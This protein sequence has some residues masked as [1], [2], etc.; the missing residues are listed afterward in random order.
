M[1]SVDESWKPASHP[2]PHSWVLTIC[3][4]HREAGPV[5]TRGGHVLGVRDVAGLELC[6]GQ[7]GPC[8]WP[9]RSTL[10]WLGLSL[11]ELPGVWVHGEHPAAPLGCRNLPLGGLRP[12]WVLAAAFRLFGDTCLPSL[13]SVTGPPFLRLLL[14]T[15]GGRG[16]S[17]CLASA[18]ALFAEPTPWAPRTGWTCRPPG[19]Q[20]LSSGT[21]K[22]RPTSQLSIAGD[23]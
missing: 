7:A 16:Q 1:G 12:G 22:D 19:G 5:V 11:P 4:S 15:E 9:S 3:R 10:Q 6:V 20:G 8:P 17:P 23:K 14:S 21:Q 13:T 18:A 2:L